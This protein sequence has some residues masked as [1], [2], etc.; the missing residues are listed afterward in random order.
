MNLIEQI[1]NT[2][3]NGIRGGQ[4]NLETVRQEIMDEY[5]GRKDKKKQKQENEL[6][7]KKL[8]YDIVRASGDAVIRQA[9]DDLIRDFNK[10][11]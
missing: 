3:E 6:M 1:L 11:K 9:I 8:F 7:I 5:R 2:Q 4:A 10:G